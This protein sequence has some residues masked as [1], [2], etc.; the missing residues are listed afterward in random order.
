M[1]KRE[2]FE[3]AEDIRLLSLYRLVGQKNREVI[4]GM[5]DENPRAKLLDCG[6]SDGEFTN[7]LA[8]KI[9]SRAVYGIEFVKELAKRAEE[10]GITV[11]HSNL[12]KN[13][14]IEGDT[15]DVVMAKHAVY[16]TVKVRK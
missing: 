10:K 11:Y 16:L 2:K 4:L 1:K 15:F 13:F 7:K 12:D 9:G 5:A 3:G 6:C 8:D 14:P